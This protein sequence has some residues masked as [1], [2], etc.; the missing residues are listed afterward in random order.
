MRAS[1]RKFWSNS[2]KKNPI[3]GGRRKAKHHQW[4]TDDVGN[5]ALSQHL[6]AVITLMRVS[7]TWGQFKL[8]LDVA[9]R[10]GAIPCNCRSWLRTWRLARLNWTSQAC[11]KSR[12]PPTETALFM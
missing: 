6:H 8:M 1:L 9:P 3:E 12:R 10:S 4:L 11:S 2:K 7:K 5:P